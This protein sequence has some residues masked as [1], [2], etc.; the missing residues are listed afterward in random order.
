[1][2]AFQLISG[3][4]RTIQRCSGMPSKCS[5]ASM[6]WPPKSNSSYARGT[7]GTSASRSR[8]RFSCASRAVASRPAP[9]LPVCGRAS[10]RT[11]GLP[12]SRRVAA[13]TPPALEKC[14][15]SLTR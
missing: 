5:M 8:T 12:S 2:H 4:W 14:S 7:P 10:L 13:Y 3:W 6:E 9:S 15:A 1:M 11:T